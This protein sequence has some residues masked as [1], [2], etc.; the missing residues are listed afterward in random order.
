MNTYTGKMTSL[1]YDSPTRNHSLPDLQRL[2]RCPVMLV[3]PVMVPPRYPRLYRYPL[4]SR[5]WRSTG[6]WARPY[7]TRQVCAPSTRY[8]VPRPDT[9]AVTHP[10]YGVPARYWALT[11]YRNI[12]RSSIN[13]TVLHVGRWECMSVVAE[14]VCGTSTIKGGQ[15]YRQVKY[16]YVPRV[17]RGECMSVVCGT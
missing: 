16:T 4:P 10:I 9:T 5:Y 17:V 2:A 14:R 13:I 3:S 12:D 8:G 15:K 6:R 7:H 11:W 1:Y